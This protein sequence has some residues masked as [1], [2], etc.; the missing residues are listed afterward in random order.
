MRSS[1]ASCAPFRVAL[2]ASLTAALVSC[3][4]AAGPAPPAPVAPGPPDGPE[5][6]CLELAGAM[7]PRSPNEPDTIVARHILVKY[8]GS[9][10]AEDSVTRSRGAACLRALEA[11][12]KAR[13]GTSF[14][15]LVKE[16][17]DEAGAASRGG[18]VGSIE[19]TDVV[20]PFANAAFELD[21]QQV[22]DVVETDFGFHVILRTE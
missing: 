5:Q 18:T 16:Y 9:K 19:R 3:A 17:S 2:L 21:V 20:P 1:S 14:E 11:R 22:S 13:A 6:A 15:D 12:D 7:R 8:A 10:R 4:G